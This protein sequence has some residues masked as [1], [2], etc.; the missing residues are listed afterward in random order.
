MSDVKIRTLDTNSMSGGSSFRPLAVQRPRE[1]IERQ[2]RQAILSG[3]LGH[4]E[5]LPSEAA[6]AEQFNV[7]R[8]TVREALSALK[9]SGLITKSAGARGGSFVRFV[10]HHA[11]DRAF[12]EQLANT[13]EVGS[14]S[15]AEVIAFRD[16]IEVPSARGAARNRTD[17]HIEKL[18]AVIE[19]EKS[20]S[21]FDAEAP[22][23]NSEF[24]QLLAEASGNRILQAVISA[25]HS[26]I[27]PMDLI[28]WSPEVAREG[29]RHHIAIVRPVAKGEPDEA[30]EAM[31]A[32][33]RF[34]A[35]HSRQL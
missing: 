18:R 34:L 22:V 13:L 17:V 19:Q 28:E 10:D 7:S 23:L 26:I 15:A 32:H 4:G 3:S 24:H 30:E 6:L 5:K 27:H 11:L 16:M 12:A 33:L 35:E 14:V 9:E 8:P 20:I 21:I 29:V 2:I 25:V 31:R 1:Q